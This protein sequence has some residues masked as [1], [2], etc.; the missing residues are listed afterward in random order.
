MLLDLMKMFVSSGDILA[1]INAVGICN[2]LSRDKSTDVKREALG[3]L[4]AIVGSS[5]PQIEWMHSDNDEYLTM[6]QSEGM[7]SRRCPRKA[8]S[9]SPHLLASLSRI[10][11]LVKTNQ[12]GKRTDHQSG[13]VQ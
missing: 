6:L 11:H 13:T 2:K 10:F 7:R 12:R 4:E 3:T 5:I 8:L 1:L 9:L